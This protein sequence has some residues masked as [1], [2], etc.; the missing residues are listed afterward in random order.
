MSSDC[1]RRVSPSTASA[2][3]RAPRRRGPRR[4][5]A[6]APSPSD[7]LQPPGGAQA[8]EHFLGLSVEFDIGRAMNAHRGPRFGRKGVFAAG[9]FRIDVDRLFYLHLAAE[10]G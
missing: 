7:G 1:W 3:A 2:A 9:L 8:V 10:G 4:G 6:C 5:H